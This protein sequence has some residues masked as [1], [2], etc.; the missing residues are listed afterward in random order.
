MVMIFTGLTGAAVSGSGVFPQAAS[1]RM[2][3]TAVTDQLAVKQLRIV[4]IYVCVH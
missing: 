4:I 3:R 2:A 1:N